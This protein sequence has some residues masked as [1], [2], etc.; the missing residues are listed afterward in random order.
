MDVTL[1]SLKDISSAIYEANKAKGWWDEPRTREE[2]NMLVV[3][4]IAE[5]IEALRLGKRAQAD[6][7]GLLMD[8]EDGFDVELF[9]TYIKDTV[10]DELADALIRLHDMDGAGLTNI[11]EWWLDHPFLVHSDNSL[12]PLE[13]FGS[14]FKLLIRELKSDSNDRGLSVTE[15][16]GSFLNRCAIITGY[17]MAFPYHEYTLKRNTVSA[18]ILLL[19]LCEDIGMDT[20]WHI[21]MKLKYNET[22][23]YKHGKR[24]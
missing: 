11:T 3:T 12:L 23:A 24:F 22:R 5:A 20:C 2:C 9:R 8:T 14:D 10:E 19:A 7:V 15:T 1:L 21:N 6:K 17:L 18:Y 4:E 13:I 16:Y